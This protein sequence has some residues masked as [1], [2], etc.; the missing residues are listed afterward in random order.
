VLD[1]NV[2]A[3][4]ELKGTNTQD[5]DRGLFKSDATLDNVRIGDDVL[6]RAQRADCR[7]GREDKRS[8]VQALRTFRGG[9]CG[10]GGSVTVWYN[11]DME[12]KS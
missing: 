2:K 4:I 9:D 5:L 12:E 1:G 3:V 10:G 7:D 8:R 11:E 6:Y